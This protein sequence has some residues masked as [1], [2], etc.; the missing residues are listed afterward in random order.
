M[1]EF[2]VTL[3]SPPVEALEQLSNYVS[4][5]VDP[6]S[7]LCVVLTLLINDQSSLT[8]KDR[9]SLIE[10]LGAIQFGVQASKRSG[11]RRMK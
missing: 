6:Y 8:A 11:F 7:R 5:D 1:S 4:Q 10:D 2:G 9:I 3:P